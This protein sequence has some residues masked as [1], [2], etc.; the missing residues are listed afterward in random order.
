MTPSSAPKPPPDGTSLEDVAAG[1]T[2]AQK[3]LYAA[4]RDLAAAINAARQ[5][6]ETVQRIAQRTGLDTVTVRNILAVAQAP[7]D[8]PRRAR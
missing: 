8:P 5:A 3:A 4:R 2:A 7:P 6:G 1:V